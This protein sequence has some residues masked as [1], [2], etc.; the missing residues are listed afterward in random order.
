MKKVLVALVLVAM[1]AF[2]GS[3]SA[4]VVDSGFSVTSDPGGGGR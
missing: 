4:A 3:A 1:M 2:A